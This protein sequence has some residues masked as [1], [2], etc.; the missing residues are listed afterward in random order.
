L[1]DSQKR[2]AFAPPS[3]GK[4]NILLD[5]TRNKR[6]ADVSEQVDISPVR[7]AGRIQIE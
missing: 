1:N 7:L 4:K 3:A 6:T 2:T 5:G